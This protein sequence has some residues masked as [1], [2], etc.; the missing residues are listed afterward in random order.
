M[1]ELRLDFG[2]L[3]GRL[4]NFDVGLN[5]GGLLFALF[6]T[7]CTS[8][9]LFFSLHPS[10]AAFTCTMRAYPNVTPVDHP[11]PLDDWMGGSGIEMTQS[12]RVGE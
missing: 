11:S 1:V 12:R 10:L 8:P 6:N 5:R 9:F 2:G 4:L 3:C 7:Q